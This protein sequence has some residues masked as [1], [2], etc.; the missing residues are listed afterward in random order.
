LATGPDR[1]SELQIVQNPSL[2]GYLIWQYGLGFQAEE[3]QRSNF[4]LAFV[5]L[6]LLLHRP[7]LELVSSTRK[8]SGLPLFA[9]KLSEEYENLLAVHS[10][11][12]ALRQ[13]SLQ[14]MALAVNRA[15]IT[16][17]YNS[18]LFRSNT[19]AKKPPVLPERIRSMA[20]AAQKVG[21]WFSR[22][23]AH[24]IASTLRVQF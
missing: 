10:R 8:S 13:L 7:S 22:M 18:G 19:S 15:L 9:A 23:S 11:A 1:L 5:V 3:G 20:P 24:Q 17:D 16:I 6:P 21:S 12:L 14:S 2:G 4:L